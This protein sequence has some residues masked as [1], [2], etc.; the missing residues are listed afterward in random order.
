MFQKFEG[1]IFCLDLANSTSYKEK[2]SLIDLITSNGG[3]VTLILN[4]KVDYLL[5]N[6]AKNVYTYKCKTAFK[7]GK[8]VLKTSYITELILKPELKLKI[9]DY[10]IKNKKS[11]DDLN[12]GLI[13]KSNQILFLTFKLN[14]Y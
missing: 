4:R 12:K 10:V 9:S 5:K 8:V 14:F 2:K 1:K 3:V 6:D 11:V 7:L 13:P